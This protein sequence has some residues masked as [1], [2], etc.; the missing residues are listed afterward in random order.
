[1]VYTH[2]SFLGDPFTVPRGRIPGC[3]LR[4]I[5]QET[6]ADIVRLLCYTPTNIS[7]VGNSTVGQIERY[8]RLYMRS[9]I[10]EVFLRATIILRMSQH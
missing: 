7:H 9:P 10:P 4:N 5:V 3:F 1:M 8:Q 6:V 2:Q